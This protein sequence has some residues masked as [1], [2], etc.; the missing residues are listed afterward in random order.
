M[1]TAY[2]TWIVL[3]G[4]G[5]S[6]TPGPLSGLITSNPQELSKM[7]SCLIHWSV[8]SSSDQ[9]DI[10]SLDTQIIGSFL[11]WRE[12]N[13]KSNGNMLESLSPVWIG[14]TL[15]S[16]L[17]AHRALPEVTLQKWHSFLLFIAYRK[18]VPQNCKKREISVLF[19]V[20][21]REMQSWL[22]SRGSYLRIVHLLPSLQDQLLWGFLRKFLSCLAFLKISW[23]LTKDLR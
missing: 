2:S 21:S 16:Q 22:F 10:T 3:V 18:H 5:T 20:H 13:L 23:G 17:N 15:S 14:C 8:I 4:A 12:P 19:W 7:Y 1:L 6:C 9:N 11:K